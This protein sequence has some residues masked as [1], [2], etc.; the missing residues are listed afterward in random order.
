[1]AFDYSSIS[2]MGKAGILTGDKGDIMLATAHV[3][4]GTS[5]N[6]RVDND[7]SPSDF[8]DTEKVFAGP[9]VTV[10]GTSLQNR[11]MLEKFQSDWKTI[12]LEMEGGPFSAGP[13]ARPSSRA[14]H[15]KI[16]P[17][18]MPIMPRTTPS[19]RV[20]P[21]AAGAMGKEGVK[22]TYLITKVILEKIM[23]KPMN[24]ET[25]A[26]KLKNL[27]RNNI[28]LLVCLLT[29][30]ILFPLLEDRRSLARGLLL[31]AIFFS[32]IFSLDFSVKSLKILL[33]LGTATAAATW[34][35]FF[36]R[37]EAVYLV[38]QVT[39]FLFLVAIVVLIIRHIA[40]SRI[41]DRTIILSSINGYLLLGVLSAALL[42][43][44]DVLHHYISASGNQAITFPGQSVPQFN[45]YIYFSFVTLTTL[46]YGDV[47]PVS[48]LARSMTHT[49]RRHRPTVHDHPHRH[50]GRQIFIPVRRNINAPHPKAFHTQFGVCRHR[51]GPF[52]DRC[53]DLPPAG[54]PRDGEIVH[55]RQNRPGHRRCIGL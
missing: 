5:D 4:E 55:R 41:V 47:T 3:F 36:E 8:P 44:S 37:N 40:R 15:V 43:I 11:D 35:G 19:K 52:A 29:L 30:I 9:M 25:K 32:G 16:C 22:P 38:D 46:G 39:T 33:P 20:A 49:H 54:Q 18:A 34:V 17:Y 26:M 2:I 21:W 53:P 50:A 27:P 24:L 1:M 31:T 51:H 48:H 23:G 28:I 14:T 45:D 10:L 7:L 13:S 6:Y 12:G 42:A